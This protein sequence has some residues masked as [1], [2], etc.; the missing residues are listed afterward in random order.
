MLYPGK[1]EEMLFKEKV[2]AWR[3]PDE[4]R[5]QKPSLS[6]RLS[7]AKKNLMQ[8]AARIRQKKVKDQSR[9]LHSP[10]FQNFTIKVIE[11]LHFPGDFSNLD[12]T[13]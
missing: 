9:A 6:L 1:F 10:F 12:R 4:D 7:W 5:S 13:K 3:T 2:N 11:N 8:F